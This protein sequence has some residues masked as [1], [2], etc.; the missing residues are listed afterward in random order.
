[1]KLTTTKPIESHISISTP[2]VTSPHALSYEFPF[3]PM[4]NSTADS[5]YQPGMTGQ[6]IIDKVSI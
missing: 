2:L 5:E 6:Q 3:S 1:M 4:G